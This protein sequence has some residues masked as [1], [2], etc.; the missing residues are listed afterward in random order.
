MF[1]PHTFSRTKAFLDEFA[2]S[3]NRAD[4]VFLCEIFGSIRENTGELTIQDLLNKIEN[5]KLID[6]HNTNILESYRNAVI[7]FMGAGDIQQI[8]R[9]YMENMEATTEF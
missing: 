4:H 3:L 1:Q 6:E 8:Q 9:A 5:A 7:L 2:E